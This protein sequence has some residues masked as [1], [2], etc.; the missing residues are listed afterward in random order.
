[1]LFLDAYSDM[2]VRPRLT[3]VAYSHKTQI[4]EMASKS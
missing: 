2:G 3:I 4:A 1:V